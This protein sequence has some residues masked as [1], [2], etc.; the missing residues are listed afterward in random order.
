MGLDYVVVTSVD[1]DDLDDQGAGH[2]AECIPRQIRA[3]NPNTLVEVLIPDFS[4][5]PKDTNC[6]RRTT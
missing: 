5:D 4:G 3:K 1:R 2:F 6:H